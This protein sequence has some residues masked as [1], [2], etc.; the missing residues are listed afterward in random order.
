[1]SLPRSIPACALIL[2]TAFALTST[3]SDKDNTVDARAQRFIEYYDATVRPLEI[4]A[5]RL[6]WIANVSGKEADYQKKQDAEDKLD[7]K[8]SDP[9]RFAELKAVKESKVE[10]PLL[11]RQ[12]D[13]IYL[14]HLGRQVPTDLLKQISA[15][16]NAVERTFNVYRY[17]VGGKKIT[18]NDISHILV[19]S[20]DS[21]LRQEAW[22]ARMSV[23]RAVLPDLKAV[24]ALRNEAAH[25]LGF[26]NFHAMQLYLGE[27]SDEQLM[28]VFDELETLTREPYHKAKAQIDAALAKKYGIA[29]ADL[30][31]W[32][33]HDPYFAEAPAVLGELP[34]AVY[35]PIDILKTCR[36]FYDGIGMPIDDVLERSDLYEKPGKCPHAFSTDIDRQGDVRILVNIVPGR[37]WLAT[38]LHELGHASYSKFLPQELPYVLRNEAHPLCTEGVAM[39]FER[40][41]QNVDWLQ[42]MGVDVPNP[43]QFRVAAAR[44]QRNRMLFF[45]RWCQVMVR[46]ERELYANP[47]QDLNRLWWS[48]VEKY[49]EVKRPDGRNEPDFAAKYHFVA[50]P[51]YYH[52][53]MLGELFASQVGHALLQAVAPNAKSPNATYVGN[54]A[55]GHFMRTRVFAPGLTLNWNDLTRHATGQDLNP[56]AFAQ[57]IKSDE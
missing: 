44:S 17:D 38:T 10:N 13:V 2:L 28:K 55:A 7:L 57:D 48:L 35:R 9:Q 36:S 43:D 29:V 39:M 21:P 27:Q 8:L 1:M 4:E 25:K 11:A 51:A 45:A 32:H 52:N 41:A 16:S 5:S 26:K 12:I 34:E 18:D 54:K 47:D 23:G 14:E 40:N 19:E 31:P 30:H 20:L 42:A 15:K 56:K 22:Q 50:A 37:E 33:Y 53:Y 24:V 49:Q 46:F 3:A 6:S